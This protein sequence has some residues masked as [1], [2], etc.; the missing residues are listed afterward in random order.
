MY[1][2]W[3]DCKSKPTGLGQQSLGVM[4]VLPCFFLPYMK[5]RFKFFWIMCILEDARKIENMEK[6]AR[7]S[8]IASTMVAQLHG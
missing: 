8:G 1:P 7:C 4:L 2:S 6:F 3:S 5:T